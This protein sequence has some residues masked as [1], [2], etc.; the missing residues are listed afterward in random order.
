MSLYFFFGQEEFNIENQI[1][2]LKKQLLDSSFKSINYKVM[3]NPDFVSII[4][5][6]LSTPMMFG[7]MLLVINLEKYFFGNKLSIDDKLLDD[8]SNALKNISSSLHIIFLCRIPRDENKKIDARKKLYKILTQ[9]CQ[10]QEF[11]QFR[12]YQKELNALIQKMI[13]SKD[14]IADSQIISFLIEQLGSNL[15]LIDSE[16]EKLKLAIYPDKQ[17]KMEDIKNNCN[18][19]DD[20]FVLSDLIVADDKNAVLRQFESLLERRHELEILSVL[21]NNLQRFI[22][23]K[24]SS[25]TMTAAEIAQNLKLHEFVVIK[26]LEKLKKVSLKN[27]IQIK[28]YLTQAEFKVKSGK[29]PSAK[30][31]V[32]E[33]L[34]R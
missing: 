31:A 4:D 32:E 13:K 28:E 27:L 34:L 8:F 23:I 18:L 1:E 22:Y 5:A 19:S 30:L 11:A 10:V 2:K 12:T 17:L 15:R 9:N 21:Q 6:C 24:T 7:N 29:L 3:D 33:A 16:L 20:I 14:M 25:L 26:I